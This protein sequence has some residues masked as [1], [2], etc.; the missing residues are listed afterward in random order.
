MSSGPSLQAIKRWILDHPGA[1][2][3]AVNQAIAQSGASP[4]LVQQ[5][6]QELR[7]QIGLGDIRNFDRTA[8]RAAGAFT[9]QGAITPAQAYQA[10]QNVGTM[11]AGDLTGNAMQLG[12]A[13][14]P[15]QGPNQGYGWATNAIRTLDP[16]AGLGVQDG[17]QMA[18]NP[19]GRG[20]AAVNEAAPGLTPGG[21]RNID[22]ETLQR[23]RQ[24]TGQA[25][26]SAAYAPQMGY[27]PGG[28]Y[29]TGGGGTGIA[30][31]SRTSPGRST[32]VAPRRQAQPM[33]GPWGMWP[34][35]Y[36]NTQGAQAPGQGPA[37]NAMPLGFGYN[38]MFA[39]A[40]NW[41]PPMFANYFNTGRN[42]GFGGL[43]TLGPLPSF[44]V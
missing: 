13:Y 44:N 30:A 29:T 26:H 12:R 10:L 33:P 18:W 36:P 40:G 41:V 28:Q 5:A 11:R 23:I 42:L 7:P 19:G 9:S 22:W 38:P 3:E 25:G 14:G 37:T 15:Q 43:N 35:G 17:Q 27:A 4:Q 34:G 6:F 24:Q 31:V 16:L 21:L 39:S 1:S 2:Q 8:T 32:P 20:F